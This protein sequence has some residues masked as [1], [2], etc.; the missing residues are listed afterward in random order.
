MRRE[1]TR[2]V[3]P[4]SFLFRLYNRTMPS[5][6]LLTWRT[7]AAR[8]LHEIEAAHRA[9]GGSGRGR[10]YATQ[11]INQA[12]AV[13]L[14]SQFQRFCRDLHSEAVDK[15]AARITVPDLQEM[16]RAQLTAGRKLSSGNPNPG[17][18]GS[19]FG[20]L[21]IDFWP[22]LLAEHTLNA[23]RR[24][25]RKIESLAERDRPPGFRP[26]PTRRAY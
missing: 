4:P 21:D 11:Q 23:S 12:C 5:R 3:R 20:R 10:R 7:E 15:L 25:A 17:N 6:S 8:A 26:R 24:D 16:F 2:K 18:I 1:R 19:D 13:L 22:A 14:S 9:V